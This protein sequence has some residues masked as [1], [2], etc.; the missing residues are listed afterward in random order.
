MRVIITGGGLLTVLALFIVINCTVVSRNARDN[1]VSS[2]L[3]SAVDY[4]VDIM[5]QQYRQADYGTRTEQE[6]LED[7]MRAFCSALKERITTDGEMNVRL[8][9]ANL[10]EGLIHIQVMEEY[11]YQMSGKVGRCSCEKTYRFL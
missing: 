8:L 9:S 3:D 1:E 2:G 6:V 7:I 11:K 4:A 10:R 5:G